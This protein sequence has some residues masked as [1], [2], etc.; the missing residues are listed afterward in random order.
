MTGTTDTADE[1]QHE[2]ELA[3]YR[4]RLHG[5]GRTALIDEA[6]ATR[7]A[8]EK[9]KRRGEAA[10]A[11]LS[12]YAELIGRQQRQAGVDRLFYAATLAG[13]ALAWLCS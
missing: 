9:C 3:R 13:F 11:L 6:V 4:V 10:A 2:A 5:F 12:H 8:L 1:R 7:D